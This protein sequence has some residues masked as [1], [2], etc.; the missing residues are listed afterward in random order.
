MQREKHKCR[1]TRLYTTWSNMK[2]RCNNPNDK[3]YRNYG[4]RGIK[5]CKDWYSFTKFRDWALANGYKEDLTIDRILLDKGYCPENCRF[6]SLAEQANNRTNNHYITYKGETKTLAQWAKCLNIPYY[7]LRSR[8]N[9]YDY[10][11]NKAFSTETYD[12]K[13]WCKYK[14]ETKRLNE[15]CKELKLN[16]SKIKRRLR[17]GWTVERAFEEE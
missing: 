17:L 14:G 15:W 12:K 4:G 13:H 1:K 6:I 10:D 3:E 16:Y 8:I 2:Q 9:L 5:V 7:R 11:L